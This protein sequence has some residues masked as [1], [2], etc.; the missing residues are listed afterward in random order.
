MDATTNPTPHYVR[1]KDA[2]LV[3]DTLTVGTVY[4]C[5]GEQDGMYLVAGLWLTR[6]RFE[7]A[8]FE[9]WIRSKSA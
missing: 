2:T 1:C 4:E 8:T 6:G 5:Q 9:D 3:R 7:P